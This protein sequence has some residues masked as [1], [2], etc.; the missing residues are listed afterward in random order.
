[1]KIVY[2]ILVCSVLGFVACSPSKEN[3]PTSNNDKV[4]S[5][6]NVM[7]LEEKI[8]QLTLYTSDYDVTGPHMRKG[9]LE[10]LK[11]G[12]VGAIFNALGAAYTRELQEIAV[13]ETR[14]GIPLLFGYDVIHGYK[15]IFP[16]PLGETA[17]W[18]LSLMEKTAQIAAAEASAEGIHWT[19]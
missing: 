2:Q 19:F 5:L 1:M 9:Y 18:D 17:S 10:D 15:T 13:K 14:L 4:D 6:L 7:T 11:A 12:K 8:G 3:S 16:I